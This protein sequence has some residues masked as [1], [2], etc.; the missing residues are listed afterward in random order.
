MDDDFNTAGA[1]GHLFDL[2]RTINQSRDQGA[3]AETLSE[4]QLLLRELTG[5]LGLNLELPEKSDGDIAPFVNVLIE[6]RNELRDQ[7]LW[8]LSDKIRDQLLKLDIVLEDGTAGTTW[9]WK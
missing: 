2:V 9:H 5:V 6:T 3:D 1:L 4:G 8:A 7:K